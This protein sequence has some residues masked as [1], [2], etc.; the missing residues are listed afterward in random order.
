MF[1]RFLHPQSNESPE[2]KPK[3]NKGPVRPAP[4]GQETPSVSPENV[5]TTIENTPMPEKKE[6][7]IKAPASVSATSSEPVI[8]DLPDE[9]PEYR[10][11]R[12]RDGPPGAV[13]LFGTPRGRARKRD[14]PDER[15]CDPDK[16]PRYRRGRFD[17][18]HPL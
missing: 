9:E 1:E 15:R 18:D 14:R 17:Y 12:Y 11:C 10:Q 2:A 4:M 3:E 13:S 5:N 8:P 6:E 7:S 16:F